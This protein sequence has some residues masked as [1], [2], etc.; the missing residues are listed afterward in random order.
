MGDIQIYSASSESWNPVS[1]GEHLFTHACSLSPSSI[2]CWG[3]TECQ[4]EKVNSFFIVQ[5]LK[6]LVR[7]ATPYCFEVG[8]HEW[9]LLYCQLGVPNIDYRETDKPS[10]LELLMP[11]SSRKSQRISGLH[12][13]GKRIIYGFPYAVAYLCFLAFFA[14]VIHQTTYRKSLS[15]PIPCN[16][17]GI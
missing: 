1:V 10:C 14:W 5:I 8:V 13:T 15:S 9:G 4:W 17:C 7:C 2:A 12:N 6:Y 11:F 16:I 3:M